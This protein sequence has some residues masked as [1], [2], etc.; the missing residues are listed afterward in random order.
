[1]PDHDGPMMSDMLRTRDAATFPTKLAGWTVL[2]V[3][4]L[5]LT[6][7]TATPTESLTAYFCLA[8]LTL[9]LTIWSGPARALSDLTVLPAA[10]FLLRLG[11]EGLD[12]G[13]LAREL[14]D[15]AIAVRPA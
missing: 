3:S 9:A 4:L 11:L 13:P 7:D 12:F 15:R 1:M 14:A 8:A 6:L 10:A 5:L 2:A